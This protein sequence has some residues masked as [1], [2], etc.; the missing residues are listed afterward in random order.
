MELFKSRRPNLNLLELDWQ[1]VLK[2]LESYDPKDPAF[3]MITINK[4]K[5]TEY[6]TKFMTYTEMMELVR[7][8]LEKKNLRVPITL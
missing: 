3:Y 7:L 2:Q 4:G 5:D 6:R 1:S 8:A